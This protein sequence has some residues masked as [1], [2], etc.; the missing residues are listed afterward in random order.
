MKVETKNLQTDALNAAATMG[1][2]MA[3]NVINKVIP[4]ENKMIKSA[5]P[6][7]VGLGLTFLTNDATAKAASYGMIAHGTLSLVRSAVMGDTPKESVNGVNL[8]SN[9]RKYLDYVIPS[10]G[11]TEDE[12]FS[13][14]YD[15]Y[16]DVTD[17][18]DE[19]EEPLALEGINKGAFALNGINEGAFALEG[20]NTDDYDQIVY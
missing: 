17:Y 4:L 1:G 18:E 14:D 2:F 5:I 15:P 19:F 16:E 20:Y 12:D 6:L 7:A 9:V 8:P 13:M 11:A 10:L 3:A